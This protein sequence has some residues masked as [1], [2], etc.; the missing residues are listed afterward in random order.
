MKVFDLVLEYSPV[1]ANDEDKS[2]SIPEENG[3]DAVALHSDK[4]YFH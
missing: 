2:E 3:G 1:F 4:S